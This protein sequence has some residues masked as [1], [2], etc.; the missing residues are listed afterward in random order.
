MVTLLKIRLWRQL[1]HSSQ[2]ILLFFCDASADETNGLKG[3]LQSFKIILGLKINYN[4]C[5][6]LGVQLL[7]DNVPM[8]AAVFGH[9][10]GSFPS[11]YLVMLL[12][13]GMPKRSLWDQVIER[14]E[15]K[16]PSW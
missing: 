15:K 14:Y 4:K 2:T 10:A 8:F 7:E 1:I 11:K 13:I 3:I 12:C 6:M 9:R 16:L 5:E